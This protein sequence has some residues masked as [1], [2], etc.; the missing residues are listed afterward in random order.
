[1]CCRAWRN[2]ERI[3]TAKLFSRRETRTPTVY[4]GCADEKPN[5]C[6]RCSASGCA[7]APCRRWPADD[8]GAR[9]GDGLGRPTA[10]GWPGAPSW[11]S[12]KP[13]LDGSRG[14]LA[15]RT[16]SDRELDAESWALD[17]LPIRRRRATSPPQPG[18]RPPGHQQTASSLIFYQFRLRF[19]L[20]RVG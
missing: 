18:G 16:L 9:S 7:M 5:V 1:V 11:I 2:K 15:L 8:R 3:I 12:R 17:E 4:D 19:Q 10:A 6:C 13:S 14:V 20:R